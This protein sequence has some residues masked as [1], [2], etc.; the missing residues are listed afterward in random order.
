MAAGGG[1]SGEGNS[2]S[3]GRKLTSSSLPVTSFGT[4]SSSA[5]V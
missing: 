3:M 5:R 1:E 2:P 4:L